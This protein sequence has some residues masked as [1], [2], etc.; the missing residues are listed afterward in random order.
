MHIMSVQCSVVS[1]VGRISKK[2][3]I[4]VYIQLISFAAQQK[5]TH[6]KANYTPIKINNKKTTPVD[7]S[8]HADTQQVC[9]STEASERFLNWVFLDQKMQDQGSVWSICRG[10]PEHLAPHCPEAVAP[11]P[12]GKSLPHSRVAG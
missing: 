2:E 11:G 8:P 7:A 5:L 4:Y 12:G 1:S 3:G 10:L 9:I 6:C